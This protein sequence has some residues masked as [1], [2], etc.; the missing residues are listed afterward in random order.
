MWKNK[1]FEPKEDSGRGEKRL[2]EAFFT[3]MRQLVLALFF[4]NLFAFMYFKAYS[5]VN[6]IFQAADYCGC[7]AV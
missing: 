2:F 6:F 5:H 4:P 3:D 1:V 7:A